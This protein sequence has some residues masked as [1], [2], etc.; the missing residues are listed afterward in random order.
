M[1]GFKD[2]TRRALR[3]CPCPQLGTT[4]SWLWAAPLWALAYEL[5]P[6]LQSL[7]LGDWHVCTHCGHGGFT[8]AGAGL[9]VPLGII[10]RVMWGVSI[11]SQRES[12]VAK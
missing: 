6:V 10:C 11:R 7:N 3:R 2:V 4:Y 12:K 1:V 8:A 9:A 5:W